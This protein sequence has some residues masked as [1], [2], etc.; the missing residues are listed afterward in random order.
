MYCMGRVCAREH[1]LSVGD[2]F[3]K[4]VVTYYVQAAFHD[5][6]I[7]ARMSVSV[8]W[9]AALTALTSAT[10]RIGLLV[11]VQTALLVFNILIVYTMRQLRASSEK[12][13]ETNSDACICRSRAEC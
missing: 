2:V 13:N 7:L 9:N 10:S 4:F 12:N 8:S 6:D 11:C 1:V 3:V 5:T